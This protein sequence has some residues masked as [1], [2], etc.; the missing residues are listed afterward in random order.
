MTVGSRRSFDS[1]EPALA[2][3]GGKLHL[4]HRGGGRDV[5]LYHASFNGS[6]W[7]T[8]L[9]TGSHRSGTGPAVIAYRDSNA[10][11]SQLLVVHR[12]VRTRAAGADTAEIASL[13]ATEAE[14][15]TPGTTDSP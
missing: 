4:A 11:Q 10:S 12:G 6:S 3:D 15:Q 8:D 13:L 5:S 9:R 2:A 1:P 7:S 14:Q